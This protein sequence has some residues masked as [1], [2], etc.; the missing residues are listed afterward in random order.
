MNQIL[1]NK[2]AN[3]Y[4]KV[5]KMILLFMIIV[6]LII[7]IKRVY[8]DFKEKELELISKEIATNVG[9]RQLY[10]SKSDENGEYLGKIIIDKINIKYIV[11]NQ[12]SEELLKICPCKFSGKSLQEKGNI[13][14]VAHNY[15]DD[16]FFG[17]INTLKEKDI[18]LIQDMNGNEYNY[19][20]YEKFETDDDDFSILKQSKEYELTLLT[21]N[22]VNDKRIIIKAY[23]K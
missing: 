9:L 17:K 14:I 10:V 23:R 4:I 1:F 16:R 12:Y 7:I 2:R 3:K 21:C 18:I 22:N 6:L 13:C 8:S 15:D 11:F 19:M 20:V 5:V